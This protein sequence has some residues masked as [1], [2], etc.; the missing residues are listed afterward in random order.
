[1][2]NLSSVSAEHPVHPVPDG[3]QLFS[4]NRS[5]F[6]TPFFLGGEEGV[7]G[8]GNFFSRKPFLYPKN[9]NS[10]A[11]AGKCFREKILNFDKNGTS[12]T[13]LCL[14]NEAGEV[15]GDDLVEWVG[16]Q[17]FV[18]CL[19]IHISQHLWPRGVHLS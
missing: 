16:L 9:H 13:T 14:F 7:L 17:V 3:G 12:Q 15:G 10:D 8:G 11:S 5:P 4:K 6:Q 2:Y 19:H 18:Q 1:M